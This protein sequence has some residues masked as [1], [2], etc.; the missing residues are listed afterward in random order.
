LVWTVKNKLVFLKKAD[1]VF[2]LNLADQCFIVDLEILQQLELFLFYKIT[3]GTEQILEIFLLEHAEIRVIRAPFIIYHGLDLNFRVV[4]VL[5]EL[6][7]VDFQ[8][9]IRI[10]IYLNN[11]ELVLC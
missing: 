3:Y 1:E 8:N 10:I 11:L 4:H 2:E 9:P 5:D 6:K 7:I